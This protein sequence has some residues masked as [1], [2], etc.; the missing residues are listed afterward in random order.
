MR[1]AR[2][3]GQ[4][5][6]R[7]HRHRRRERGSLPEIPPTL[8]DPG[9]TLEHRSVRTFAHRDPNRIGG[10]FGGVVVA[11]AA[12]QAR[13]LNADDR[14]GSGVERIA[15][16]QRFGT[17]GVLLQLV[18]LARESP[19][20]EES[21]EGARAPRSLESTAGQNP[22]QLAEHLFTFTHGR[23]VRHETRAHCRPASR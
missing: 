8:R 23:D 1:P 20:Q 11:Q 6:D 4:A 22:F 5:R 2:P 13:D 21:Q 14:V 9:S 3:H 12:S 15:T 16:S 7:N 18:R 19:F 17:D 10:P